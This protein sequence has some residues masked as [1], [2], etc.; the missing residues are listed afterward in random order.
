MI[1]NFEYVFKIKGIDLHFS[2]E[3]AAMLMRDYLIPEL[4]MVLGRRAG[5]WFW[6]IE[7]PQQHQISISSE[8]QTLIGVG[9]PFPLTI[10]KEKNGG[11]LK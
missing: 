3:A 4:K 9:V 6:Q 2:M 1:L 10:M 11:F 8:I 7:L 5:A